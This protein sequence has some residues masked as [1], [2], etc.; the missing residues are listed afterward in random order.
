MLFLTA[1][2]LKG[3]E[4]SSWSHAQKLFLGSRNTAPK[5]RIQEWGRWDVRTNEINMTVVQAE[6]KEN[7]TATLPSLR[8]R[9]QELGKHEGSQSLVD[10][11]FRAMR[12]F[13]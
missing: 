11:S 4:T 8:K 9:L 13:H 6:K 10:Q 5:E 12:N 7:N 3:K 1:W 2:R